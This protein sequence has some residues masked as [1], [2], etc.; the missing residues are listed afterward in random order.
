VAGAVWD[1]DMAG[2][3]LALDAATGALRFQARL[4]GQPSHF[5]APAYGGGQV[6]VAT[7]DGVAAF[8]L[9]GLN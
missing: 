7:G 2:R 9:L 5:A 6:Y 8:H 1:I 4:P 3:L